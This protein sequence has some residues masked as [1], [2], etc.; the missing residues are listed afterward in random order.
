G[1]PADIDNRRANGLVER[2]R[3]LAEALYPCT[4]AQRIPKGPSDYESDVFHR[5]MGVY[6]QIAAGSDLQIEES[7]S[8]KALEH[9]IE[10]RHA[11]FRLAASGAV[12]LERNT[13]GSLARLALDF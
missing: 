3:R 11:R 10:E 1:A 2:H 12:E 13:H 5:V 4:I 7:V 9:V 6:L 8:R